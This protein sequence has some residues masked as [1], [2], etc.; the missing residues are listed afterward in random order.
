MNKVCDVKLRMFNWL[1]FSLVVYSIIV[2]GVVLIFSGKIPYSI[3]ETIRGLSEY[4]GIL[5]FISN[6]SSFSDIAQLMFVFNFFI[7]PPVFY[8][9]HCSG[10]ATISVKER[11]VWKHLF[12]SLFMLIL[13]ISSVYIDTTSSSSCATRGCSLYEKIFNA[14]IL[15]SI[16]L[17]VFLLIFSLAF[18]QLVFCISQIM[19]GKNDLKGI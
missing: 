6:H 1:A 19:F 17:S 15:F 9:I 2:F 3:S 11:G 4:L 18:S 10:V 12:A 13:L 7:I 16:Y 8:V 5:A 14:E